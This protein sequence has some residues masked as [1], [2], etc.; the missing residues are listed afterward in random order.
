MATA[1]LLSIGTFGTHVIGS[2]SGRYSFAG[3]VPT[4]I[5]QGGYTSE[6]D[7]IKAF[8]GWFIDQDVEFKRAHVADL[9]WD[10]FELVLTTAPQ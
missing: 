8:A 6:Q 3:D 2:S 9:R 10:V 4:G 7:A 5:K 1:P